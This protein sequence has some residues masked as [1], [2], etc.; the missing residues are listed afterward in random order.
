MIQLGN[1]LWAT[2]ADCGKLV[3]LTGWFRGLH[4]CLT[5]EEI[6]AK[7]AASRRSTENIHKPQSA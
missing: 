7:H 1:H 2:C 4:L 5:P 3:K 6:A